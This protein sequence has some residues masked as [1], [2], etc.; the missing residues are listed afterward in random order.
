MYIHNKRGVVSARGIRFC[1][2]WVSTLPSGGK[3]ASN[4]ARVARAKVQ[5]TPHCL[6]R[7]H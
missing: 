5:L 6:G 2:F 3:P 4:L 7:L 1:L